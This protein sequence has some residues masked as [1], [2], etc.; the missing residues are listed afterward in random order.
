MT[1]KGG[2]SYRPIGGYGDQKPGHRPFTLG[3]HDKPD[4][5]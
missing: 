2:R 1:S 3:A 5:W 4:F